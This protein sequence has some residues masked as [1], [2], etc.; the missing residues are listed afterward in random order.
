MTLMR[1]YFFLSG[2]GEEDDDDGLEN[3]EDREK[4]LHRTVRGERCS[5]V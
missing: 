3:S 1:V 5:L 2:D 4:S